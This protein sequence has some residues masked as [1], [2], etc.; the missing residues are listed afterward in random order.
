MCIGTSFLCT[1]ANSKNSQISTLLEVFVKQSFLVILDGVYVWMK[2]QIAKISFEFPRQP[3]TWGW[4]LRS[5]FSGVKHFCRIF[6]AT[7]V[8]FQC[9]RKQNDSWIIWHCVDYFTGWTSGTFFHHTMSSIPTD[10]RFCTR[11]KHEL[12]YGDTYR[13]QQYS[14]LGSGASYNIYLCTTEWNEP[15][16]RPKQHSQFS[17]RTASQVVN[18]NYCITCWQ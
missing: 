4:V 5:L 12:T 15:T 16:L 3:A 8:W 14:A 17:M 9:S 2:G 1:N 13:G 18:S 7:V 6:Y 11:N 10:G